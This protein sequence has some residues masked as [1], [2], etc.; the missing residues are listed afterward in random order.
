[1]DSVEI[2]LVSSQS[3]HL[4]PPDINDYRALTLR[5]LNMVPHQV[6]PL[7]Q[8]KFDLTGGEGVRGVGNLRKLHFLRSI[9]ANSDYHC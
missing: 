1:M 4:Q 6:L 2:A 8:D 7:E 5:I 9:K 3:S